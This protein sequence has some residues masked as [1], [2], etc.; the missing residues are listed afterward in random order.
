MLT[1]QVWLNGGIY[2]GE[3]SIGSFMAVFYIG[4]DNAGGAVWFRSS[5]F[6]ST[7][8][9]A[10]TDIQRVYPSVSYIDQILIVTWDHRH[11]LSQNYRQVAS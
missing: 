1:F 8:E 3:R 5:T 2:Y 7:N 4:L 11:I 9:R 10:L 6:Q